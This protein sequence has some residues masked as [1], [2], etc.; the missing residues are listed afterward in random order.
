MLLSDYL[1][2]LLSAYGVLLLSACIT[3]SSLASVHRY[4]YTGNTSQLCYQTLPMRG[5]VH[6]LFCIQCI[7]TPTLTCISVLQSVL[8]YSAKSICLVLYCWTSYSI[9]KSIHFQ[10]HQR[11]SFHKYWVTF[12]ILF[13]G[14]L[15]STVNSLK[16]PIL[17]VMSYISV[18]REDT[19]CAVVT[20]AVVLMACPHE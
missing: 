7:N 18:P 4:R 10:K 14:L 13:R 5:H 17:H 12:L 3:C 9:Y 16:T 20:R 8:Y 6:M 11:P 1:V 15:I 2:L 19:M